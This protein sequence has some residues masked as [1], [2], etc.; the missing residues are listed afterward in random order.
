M[1][2]CTTLALLTVAIRYSLVL[3][4]LLVAFDHFFLTGRNT[5]AAAERAR[6]VLEHV[7]H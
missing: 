4:I 7:A 2:G 5:I 6:S 1:S 3:L